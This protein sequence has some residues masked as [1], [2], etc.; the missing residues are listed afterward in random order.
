MN[1]HCPIVF[2]LVSKFLMLLLGILLTV[3]KLDNRQHGK[4]DD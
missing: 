1:R 3:R 2:E 4:Q